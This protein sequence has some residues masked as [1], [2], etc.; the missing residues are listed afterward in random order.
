MK[1]LN[2]FYQI[3]GLEP[4]VSPAE[5]RQAY[6]DLAKVWHPD[7]FPHDPRLQLKTQEKLKEINEAYEILSSYQFNGDAQSYQASAEPERSQW[8][9]KTAASPGRD[10]RDT[11]DAP[12][13]AQ[14]FRQKPRHLFR[15]V[16]LAGVFLFLLSGFFS[17][18]LYANISPTLFN[19]ANELFIINNDNFFITIITL[20]VIIFSFI[21]GIFE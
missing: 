20:Y 8:H 1:V 10:P 3:L 14:G 7:R 4:G 2:R 11:T 12:P 18:I 16:S 13:G 5:I 6:R 9:R 15:W 19:K 21:K 17:S